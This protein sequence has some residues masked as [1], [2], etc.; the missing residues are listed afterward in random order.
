[1]L[2]ISTLQEALTTL[3]AE[4][5]HD[6]TESE[7]FDFVTKHGIELTAA[8]PITSSTTIWKLENEW[9][10]KNRSGLV[11]KIRLPKGHSQL[12]T[13]FPWQTSQL[14]IVGETM[15]SHPIDHDLIEGE[16]KWLTEPILITRAEVRLTKETM[17]RIKRVYEGAKNIHAVPENSKFQKNVITTTQALTAFEE[18]TNPFNLRK[19]LSDKPKWIKVA[20]IDS[21]KQGSR[22]GTWN[23][24][25]LAIALR[26]Q[27]KIP[28]SKLTS[29]FSTHKFLFDWR[30][31]WLENSDY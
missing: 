23:P 3:S 10:P 14:W 9:N 31:D 22:V 26:D 21:G 1:M 4:T 28:K 20:C 24:L 27:K 12:A 13:L 7:L 8:V 19:L 17:L 6:W 5:G 15:T 16:Y 11:E 25:L 2:R 18:M 30:D 29:A